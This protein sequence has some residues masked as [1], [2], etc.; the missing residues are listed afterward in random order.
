MKSSIILI[1]LPGAGKTTIGSLLANELSL[2]FYDTDLLIEEKYQKKCSEIYKEVGGEN[3][4]AY[5]IEALQSLSSKTPSV[6]SVGGGLPE[7]EGAFSLLDD[8]GIC[9]YLHEEI[10]IV[11]NRRMQRPLP[12]FAR[13]WDHYRQSIIQRIPHYE[14]L[15]DYVIEC[16]N[17]SPQEIVLEI[18]GI[19]NQLKT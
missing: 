3:F 12:H 8:L 15:A 4:R 2:P 17:R 13:D 1:G 6:I 18:E 19:L 10:D 11:I 5:E 14:N 16:E 9:F 7:I